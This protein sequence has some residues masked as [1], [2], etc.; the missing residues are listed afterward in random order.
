MD[1]RSILNRHALRTVQNEKIFFSKYAYPPAL[2]FYKELESKIQDEDSKKEGEAS[3]SP[4]EAKKEAKKEAVK[5]K[6]I[7]TK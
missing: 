7:D 5:T 3:A 1:W 4:D 2:E 6:P